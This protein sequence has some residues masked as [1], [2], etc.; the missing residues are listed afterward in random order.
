M[1]VQTGVPC[2][3]T[4]DSQQ[5]L[6]EH[7]DTIHNSPCQIYHSTLLLCP[8]SSWLHEC[9]AAELSQ[10][11]KVVRGLPDEWGT[12]SRTV[13]FDD[14]P[15]TLTCGNS[16][17]AVGLSSREIIILD[18]I[19]GSQ[20]AVLSG[21]TGSVRSLAFSPGGTSLVSGS[22]DKT[23]KLWDMQ[24]GGVVK[25]FYGHTHQVNSVSISSD[26]TRI[27]SGS[28]DMT[29][30]LWNIQTGEC[31]HTIKQQ[32]VIHHI[33]FSPI[34][35]GHLVSLSGNKI[36]Q[37]NISGHQTGPT[38]DGSHISFSPDNTQFALCNETAV[39]VQNYNSGA[40]VAEFAVDSGNVWSCCF[41][42]DGRFVAAAA[43]EA[44]Y[45]WDIASSVP[46]FVESCGDQMDLIISLVFSSSS[47][48]ISGSSDKSVKFWKFGILSKDPVATGPESAPSTSA[49]IQSISLQ[50]RDG[51]AISSDS[52]G[53]VKTWDISTG[54]C[55]ASFQTPARHHFSGDAQMV[56]GKLIFIWGEWRL[57]IWDVGKGELL[58]KLDTPISLGLRISEDGSKLFCLGGG[59]IQAW[60]MCTWKCMGK[61]GLEW[62]SFYLDSFR[63]GGSKIWV[64]FKDSSIQGWDFGVSDSPPVPLSKTF[65]ERPHLD[66]IGHP[67]WK[68]RNLAWI[69]DIV[70][71]KRV[72]Q[73]SGR[74]AE[75]CSV[76]WDGRYLVVGYRSGEV[77]ILDFNGFG[78]Q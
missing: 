69:K 56:D 36:H 43:G 66:F 21:H 27:A 45:V 23:V 14:V 20:A 2:K 1:L 30:C 62:G 33:S 35:P 73:L 18:A 12:C 75:F 26:C 13:H 8:P 28:I 32:H 9:Y 24:T 49:P 38:Y 41:S 22:Q 7:F 44:V 29:I 58:Q 64:Q 39:T 4:N 57:H 6:L 47:C 53:V 10:V 72:F 70:T 15:N 50:A 55:K 37:I 46:C 65:T 48:L 76:Q 52:A 17:I 74:Y 68:N 11:V 78:S 54:L 3:W 51:I 63:P 61:V 40:I 67:L 31:K 19:T 34:D 16:T 59:V 25:T 42:P 71:G 60:D 77:V 5:F